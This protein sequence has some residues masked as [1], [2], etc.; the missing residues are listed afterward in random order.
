MSQ[1]I[2]T[3]KEF[4]RNKRRLITMERDNYDRII[5][6]PRAGEKGVDKNWYEIAEHSALI[7][8]YEVCEPLGESVNFTNDVDSYYD[9]YEIGLVCMNGS[10]K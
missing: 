5:M 7:Y 4:R 8:Y 9:R 2:V 3:S 10:N 6:L 1:K